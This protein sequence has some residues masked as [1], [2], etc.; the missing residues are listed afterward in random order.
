[1]WFTT[2]DIAV[3]EAYREE[4]RRQ[5]EPWHIL[6]RDS[7]RRR[8]LQVRYARLMVGFGA[9]LEQAGCRLKARYKFA[10]A[11]GARSGIAR[12]GLQSC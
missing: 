12:G 11:D 2:H 8:A 1:M 6:R 7:I 9:W 10:P 5:A 3:Q 4:M